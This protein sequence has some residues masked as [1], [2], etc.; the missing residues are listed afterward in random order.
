MAMP[1]RQQQWSPFRYHSF[2]WLVAAPAA[3]VV[4]EYVMPTLLS[5]FPLDEISTGAASSQRLRAF[6]PVYILWSRRRH[7]TRAL[8]QAR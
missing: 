6:P 5:Y 8:T 7:N 2:Y 4:V 1:P 3:I